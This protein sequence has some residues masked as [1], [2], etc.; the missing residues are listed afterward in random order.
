MH[1]G[2]V[3]GVPAVSYTH[4]KGELK[5]NFAFALDDTTRQVIYEEATSGSSL[6]MTLGEY[7]DKNHTGDGYDAYLNSCGDELP[8]IGFVFQLDSAMGIALEKEMTADI[9]MCIRDRYSTV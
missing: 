1:H 7:V 8:Q 6:I 5:L 2:Y 4:L 3:I 9:K